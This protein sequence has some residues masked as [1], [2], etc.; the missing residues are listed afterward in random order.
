MNQRREPQDLADDRQTLA[1]LRGLLATVG[2]CRQHRV[3]REAIAHIN[4]RMK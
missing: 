2:S 4:R 3:I 1:R